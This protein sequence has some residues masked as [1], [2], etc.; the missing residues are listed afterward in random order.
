MK[1]FDYIT[2]LNIPK[3]NNV[4]VKKMESREDFESEIQQKQNLYC[5]YKDVYYDSNGLIFFNFEDKIFNLRIKKSK[6]EVGTYVISFKLEKG[7]FEDEIQ[8]KD[9]S[10]FFSI[11]ASI[12]KQNFTKGTSFKFS[13]EKRKKEIDKEKNELTARDKMYL[14]ILKSIPG[15][16]VSE[17]SAEGITFTI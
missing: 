8:H 13:G 2:E 15:I 17:K 11:I 6:E 5:Y 14:R 3:I 1:L 4:I 7:G 10:S 12:I 9:I 16:K